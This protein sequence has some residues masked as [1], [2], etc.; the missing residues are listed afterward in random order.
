MGHEGLLVLLSIL[1]M[2]APVELDTSSPMLRLDPRHALDDKPLAFDVVR[3]LPA[4]QSEIDLHLEW[5]D[6]TAEGDWARSEDWELNA[7][8][9]RWS[10]ALNNHFIV[11]NIG[12]AQAVASFTIEY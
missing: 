8:H 2:S 4:K 1:R 10:L 5:R 12:E 11:R 6:N 7:T 3:E 9:G